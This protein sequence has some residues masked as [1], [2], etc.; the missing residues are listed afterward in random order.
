MI[1]LHHSFSYFADSTLPLKIFCFFAQVLVVVQAA[2]GG[3][4]RSRFRFRKSFRLEPQPKSAVR[5][6]IRNELRQQRVSCSEGHR[7]RRA[8]RAFGE[9]EF[10]EMVS[11]YFCREAQV[12][13][14]TFQFNLSQR[15]YRLGSGLPG[16]QTVGDGGE[17]ICLVSNLF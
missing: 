9:D 11:A 13:S 15:Y 10:S 3:L 2:D 7:H 14:L 17:G 5:R 8:Q 16:Q 1:H 12:G 4:R 6:R